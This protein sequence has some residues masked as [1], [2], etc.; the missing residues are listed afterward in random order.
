MGPRVKPSGTVDIISFIIFFL[1]LFFCLKSV[2]TENNLKK[3]LNDFADNNKQLELKNIDQKSD[4]EY[5]ETL[6]YKDLYAKENLN[7]LQK[8]EELLIIKQ[9]DIVS[10]EKIVVS[11][12]EEINPENLEVID[13][14][15][16]YFNM[17]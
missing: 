17:I 14:W 3:Y 6:Q 11:E 4:L 5:Y 2:H 10:H 8:G 12:L 15:T 16:R 9:D 1:L 13:Q 7:L